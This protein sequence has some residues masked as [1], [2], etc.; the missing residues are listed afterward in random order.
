MKKSLNI[1]PLAK[2]DS[3]AINKL[4]KTFNLEEDEFVGGCE[5][6][7]YQELGGDSILF[8]V[9]NLNLAHKP[10]EYVDINEFETYNNMFIKCI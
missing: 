9:G 5:A 3:N 1:F 6:G 7:Y 4:P 2:Q 10:N 8:G